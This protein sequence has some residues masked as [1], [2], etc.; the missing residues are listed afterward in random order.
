MILERIG[1]GAEDEIGCHIGDGYLDPVDVVVDV[2]DYLAVDGEDMVR[3]AYL[4][5]VGL[6][7]FEGVESPLTVVVG[8][9]DGLAGGQGAT[10]IVGG[11]GA[12]GFCRRDMFGDSTDG[13]ELQPTSGG[14][15]CCDGI[16][17]V[18]LLV[19]R[20]ARPESCCFYLIAVG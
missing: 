17:D 8:R 20:E 2:I 12:R 10:L 1:T 18:L 11:F 14:Q 16:V 7:V 13:I 3:I 5:V 15:F 9:D 19:G 4:H 6:G